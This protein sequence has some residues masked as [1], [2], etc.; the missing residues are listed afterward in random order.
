MGITYTA[1]ACGNATMEVDEFGRGRAGDKDKT[2]TQKAVGKNS[3]TGGVVDRLN[4]GAFHDKT[5]A[6]H[7]YLISRCGRPFFFYMPV[8]H[9]WLM[10]NRLDSDVNSGYHDINEDNDSGEDGD[11]HDLPTHSTGHDKH[12][13]AM[14]PI[15]AF[16]KVEWWRIGLAMLS[17]N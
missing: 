1:P 10:L 14:P 9:V 17:M 3:G 13:E 8:D 15:S 2:V 5:I 7:Q 16:E 4:A 12:A 6:Y 11:G